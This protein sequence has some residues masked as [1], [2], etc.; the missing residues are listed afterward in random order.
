MYISLYV[1]MY[2]WIYSLA[3]ISRVLTLYV[4]YLLFVAGE[5]LVFSL[6]MI[7]IVLKTEYDS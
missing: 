2:I 3:S 1:Y 6:H 5:N 7:R 4:C